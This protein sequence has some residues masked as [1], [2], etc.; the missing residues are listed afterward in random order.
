MNFYSRL[1][2]AVDDENPTLSP[3]KFE[4]FLEIAREDGHDNGFDESNRQKFIDKANETYNLTLEQQEQLLAAWD[5]GKN[6]GD[7]EEL[8]DESSDEEPFYESSYEEPFF[9][10]IEEALTNAGFDVTRFTDLGK[11]SNNI[12]WS[13][14]N[15]EG[16]VDLVA[17]GTVLTET[18]QLSGDEYKIMD[19]AERR[20]SHKQMTMRNC[21]VSDIR[22]ELLIVAENYNK[23]NGT[24]VDPDKVLGY[25]RRVIRNEQVEED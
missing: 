15:S 4:R 3:D 22:H 17:S 12:G 7:I 18:E 13:I 2:E 23:H 9:A 24:N 1:L 21:D 19:L 14:S 16:E 11:L 6:D 20:L 8:A 25:I 5:E 10:S